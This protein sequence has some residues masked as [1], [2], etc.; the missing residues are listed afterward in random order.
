VSDV[1]PGMS[2]T[3]SLIP[4]ISMTIAPLIGLPSDP[5]AMPVIFA[6]FTGC[7]WMSMLESSWPTLSERR[8]ASAGLGVPG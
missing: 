4:G 8:C 1:P 7:S 5:E 2:A 3:V 6:S